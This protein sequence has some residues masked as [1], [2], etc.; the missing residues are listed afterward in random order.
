MSDAKER[1]VA[2]WLAKVEEDLAVARLLIR[3][4]KRLLGAGV[5]HCQQAAEKALKALLTHREVVFPKTHDLEVL[6]NLVARPQQDETDFLHVAARELTPLATVFRYPGDLHT[7]LAAE[8]EQALRHAEEIARFAQTM[9][10]S[11][12]GA[13]D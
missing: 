2:A 4:E 7:P 9:G 8:A 10:V 6:L 12:P 11:H 13:K 5:Y 3:D 1:L